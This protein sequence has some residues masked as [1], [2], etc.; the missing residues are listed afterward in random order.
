M[1]P[2]NGGAARAGLFNALFSERIFLMA[3]RFKDITAEIGSDTAK[4]QTVLNG[5]KFE[6]RNTQAQLRDGDYLSMAGAA[7][8]PPRAISNRLTNRLAR[9]RIS[10]SLFSS[11]STLSSKTAV[12]V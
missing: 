9:R 8:L 7:T 3:N 11:V 12:G 5:V 10:P 4:L 1:C 2:D 6:I